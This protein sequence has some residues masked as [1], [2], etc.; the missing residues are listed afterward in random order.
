MTRTRTEK[1]TEFV[2]ELVA[3]HKSEIARLPR[4][5]VRGGKNAARIPGWVAL[6][7]HAITRAAR[8]A[9]CP[10]LPSYASGWGCT[11][12]QAIPECIAYDALF[13]YHEIFDA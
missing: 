5:G 1:L 3:Q 13:A 12:S 7:N 2:A 10:M 6:G 11:P 9:G 4:R 8:H